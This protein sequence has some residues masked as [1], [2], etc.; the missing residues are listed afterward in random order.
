MMW[1]LV[2]GWTFL[3]SLLWIVRRFGPAAIVCWML[4]GHPPWYVAI[5][6]FWIVARWMQT[7][8]A[9]WRWSRS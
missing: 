7:L 6:A 8:Y 4:F 1:E 9:R 3:E 5:A 2:I